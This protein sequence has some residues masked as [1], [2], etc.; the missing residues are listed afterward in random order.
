MISKDKIPTNLLTLAEQSG[1]EQTGRIDEVE[2]LCESFAQTWPDAIRSFEY[3]WSAE[4]RPMRALIVSR[5][6]AL[7]FQQ[8][9]AKKIPL[10]MLQGGIH[11]GESDGKDAGFIALRELLTGTAAA[12][13]LE[14]LA[15]L[16][17]PAFN[18]DGH[19]RVGRWNRLNQDGP[20]ETGWRATAQN[21]NL[22]RDYTKADSPEMQ[23]MLRLISEWDPLVCADLHVTDG[24][25]FEPDISL[26][27][28]P[29]YQGDPALHAAGVALR[30]EL[31]AKLA[32]Q[33]SLPLPF[34]PDLVETD[35]P[36]SGFHI[37]VYS[38]RFST[39]YF[40]YRNRFTVLVETHSWKNY[41]T[42]VRVTR[43]TIVGL[44]ELVVAN[45][46]QLLEQVQRSDAKASE[47]A[48][49][50]VVLDY[51]TSWR[52]PTKRLPDTSAASNPDNDPNVT[53]IAF[54]GYAYTR[55]P[56]KISGEPVTIYDPKT[57]Q[58]W[59][60]PLRRNTQP[61]LVVKAPLAGYIV[62]AGHA[63]EIGAKLEMHGIAF[64]VLP[65][66]ISAADVSCFRAERAEFANTPFEGRMRVKLHGSWRDER[67]DIPSGSLSVSI[68]QPLSRLLMALLEPQAPD[69]FAAWGF[70]NGWFEQ[71]EYIEPYVAEM[72]AKDLL[73]NDANLAA[74]FNRKLQADPSFAADPNA[75]REFFH[76]R[77]PSWD[78]RFGLY[79]I[80]R[81]STQL[82]GEEQ[83]T[84]NLALLVKRNARVVEG[85]SARERLE[86][87]ERLA[88]AQGKA[89]WRVDLLKLVSKY[90]GETEKN[91]AR[92]FDAAE[93]AGAILFFEEGDALFKR[94]DVRDSHD[95]YA[96][97]DGGTTPLIGAIPDA[98]KKNAAVGR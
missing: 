60:V 2:R 95:R 19:E 81:T 27:V 91:L 29:I 57:P 70:F 77:H 28:E 76:R 7:T 89:L 55:A 62:T 73:S 31:I 6:G 22:N 72:I 10:L 61:S 43:N 20:I 30:D 54:Q 65:A 8:I 46:Q 35:N 9:R 52:E 37:T 87:A 5:T 34:Y 38:P 83:A 49:E 25:D 42:R 12:G 64:D 79:P 71:K 75:R 68:Q 98:S 74:E 50:H 93:H 23:A 88:S 69:S 18:V 67:Q 56:S 53:V 82:T 48:G 14:Q 44:T 13:S 84:S 63:K 11:P 21:L 32:A 36:A 78:Q 17:V 45:G 51:A 26:Q 39:G 4:G 15:I 90:I 92:V 1:F 86:N 33:G 47:L 3:G 16:F 58:S 85:A 40:A 80:Y 59:R 96:L 97:P 94:A 41:A 24:A 66:T